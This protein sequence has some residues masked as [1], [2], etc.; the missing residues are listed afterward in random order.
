MGRTSKRKLRSASDVRKAVATP[1]DISPAHA[2]CAE[3]AAAKRPRRSIKAV[4]KFNPALPKSDWPWEAPEPLKAEDQQTTDR[5]TAP[6]LS[7]T[8]PDEL[9]EAPVEIEQV[10]KKNEKLQPRRDL[11]GVELRFVE[12]EGK[13]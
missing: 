11:S 9:R 3:A 12:A 6:T 4:P 10:M 8:A 2:A 1:K 5:S 13:W 7:Q